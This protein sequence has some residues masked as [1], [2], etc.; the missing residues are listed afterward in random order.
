MVATL[1]DDAGGYAHK[2]IESMAEREP[3]TELNRSFSSP[4]A[5][6]RAWSEVVTVLSAAELFWLRVG[7]GG[8]GRRESH[9]RREPT[10]TARGTVE[11]KAQLAIRSS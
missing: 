9:Y 4:D 5:G 1:P 6:P 10:P 8:R 11:I 3:I 2:G 7:C